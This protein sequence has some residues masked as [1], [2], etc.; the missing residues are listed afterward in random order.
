[1]QPQQQRRQ[2]GDVGCAAPGFRKALP[3]PRECPAASLVSWLYSTAQRPRI[4]TTAQQG[5][6]I[7]WRPHMRE[8]S[9]NPILNAFCLVA[10]S[11]RFSVL[12]ILAAGVFFRASDFKSRTCAVVQGRLLDAFFRIYGLRLLKRRAYKGKL[13]QKKAPHAN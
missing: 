2:R 5:H 9:D 13:S 7:M 8:S 4:Q 1:M 10:P 11:V 12:A 6:L 3:H